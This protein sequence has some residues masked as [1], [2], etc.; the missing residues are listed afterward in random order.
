M[1][2]VDGELVSAMNSLVSGNF[3]G[4]CRVRAGAQSR[5]TP[6]NLRVPGNWDVNGR[7]FKWDR[8]G[9]SFVV[10]AM[11]CH[12]KSASYS[13]GTNR[14]AGKGECGRKVFG[15]QWHESMGRG[16]PGRIVLCNGPDARRFLLR[17]MRT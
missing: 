12:P 15:V 4:K 3:A 9:K 6:K 7:E 11:V 17:H 2:A 1:D 5:I 16:C 8:S 14:H 13:I 10:S